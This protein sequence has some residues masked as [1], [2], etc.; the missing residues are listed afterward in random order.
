MVVPEYGIW[1]HEVG[2]GAGEEEEAAE[3]AQ[4]VEYG[5][6]SAERRFVW[7]FG[8]WVVLRKGFDVVFF[9]L[10]GRDRW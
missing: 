4:D 6:A 2:E 10:P 8:C 9:Y 7:E 5:D 3:E 1:G